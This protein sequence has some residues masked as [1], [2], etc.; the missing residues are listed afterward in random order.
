MQSITKACVIAALLLTG[1]SAGAQGIIRAGKAESK[2]GDFIRQQKAYQLNDGKIFKRDKTGYT[3]PLRDNEL[4][5]FQTKVQGD[6]LHGAD[7]VRAV[8]HAVKLYNDSVSAEEL[9]IELNKT[10]HVRFI[11]AGGIS[12]IDDVRKATGN[13]SIGIQFRLSDFKR[14]RSSLFRNWLDPH[15][16][17]LMFNTRTGTSSDT[18]ILVRTFLFPELH[19]RDFVL[20]YFWHME[21][22]NWGIEPLFE[23][24]LSRYSD[25]AKT[26]TFR[27][28]SFILGSK[29]YKRF[30]VPINQ[31]TIDAVVQLFPY[32]NMINVD[33]KYWDAYQTLLSPEGSDMLKPTW[34][35]VGLQ[36]MVQIENVTMFCNMKYILNRTKDIHNVDLQRFVYT[37]GTMITL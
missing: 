22:N 4:M 37:I 18:E 15:Y 24:S 9:R 20:G 10:S 5:M 11:A 33:P 21:K 36:A 14:S 27:T 12:N 32:Y 30:T 35:S 1:T 8:R 28:E 2:R 6:T 23:G 34:H 25:S 26:T 13:L 16:I 31:D 17:Y 7:S 29:F 19:K 3:Q